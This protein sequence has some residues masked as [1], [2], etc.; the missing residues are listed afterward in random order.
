[1]IFSHLTLVIILMKTLVAIRLQQEMAII[2]EHLDSRL[3]LL[4]IIYLSFI[5]LGHVFAFQYVFPI[6]YYF[7]VL[8]LLPSFTRNLQQ[9]VSAYL[10]NFKMVFFVI[11]FLIAIIIY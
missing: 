3:C 11:V 7:C 10:M 6:F 5:Y 1:M 8:H 2:P 9:I 4:I